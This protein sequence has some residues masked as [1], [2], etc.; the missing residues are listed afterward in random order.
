MWD[1]KKSAPPSLKTAPQSTKYGPPLKVWS[2][3]PA[4][5]IGQKHNEPLP[6][7]STTRVLYARDPCLSLKGAVARVSTISSSFAVLQRELQPCLLSCGSQVRASSYRVLVCSSGWLP[8]RLQIM[9]VCLCA[10]AWRARPGAIPVRLQI[11][12]GFPGADHGRG[13]DVIPARLLCS[14]DPDV[15]LGSLL[16]SS[17]RS[18]LLVPAAR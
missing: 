3:L 16:C 12:A 15:L 13:D 2:K 1:L 9:V 6:Q 5:A 14:A 8:A 18:A 7:P 17:R 11:T 4:I 10:C